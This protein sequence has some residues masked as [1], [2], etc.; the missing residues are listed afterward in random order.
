MFVILVLED[1][2]LIR[3]IYKD[4]DLSNSILEINLD[5]LK[6]F[7]AQL[8]LR[9]SATSIKTAFRIALSGAIK[10]LEVQNQTIGI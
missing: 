9:L 1:K 3:S 10:A 6:P 5:I 2:Q 8:G 4:S 7:I